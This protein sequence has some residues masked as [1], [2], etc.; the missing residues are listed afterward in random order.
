MP[1]GPECPSP[2]SCAILKVL[3]L[4]MKLRAP[5]EIL[6]RGDIGAHLE[7]AYPDE[8][9]VSGRLDGMKVE[10]VKA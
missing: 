7:E 4:F 10:G 1:P 9:V 2:E 5:E 6:E 8:A 3:G